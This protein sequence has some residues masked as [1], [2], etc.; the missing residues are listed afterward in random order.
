M[1]TL[2]RLEDIARFHRLL[3]EAVSDHAE[4]LTELQRQ[5]WLDM[6]GELIEHAH[7]TIET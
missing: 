2:E 1:I 7:G 4:P 3:Q 5:I 6:V